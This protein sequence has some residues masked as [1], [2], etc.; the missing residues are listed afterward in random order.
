M[1]RAPPQPGHMATLTR[2]ANAL[3]LQPRR[4]WQF[5]LNPALSWADV[6]PETKLRL[7]TLPQ[8]TVRPS[9]RTPLPNYQSQ[10][11]LLLRACSPAYLKTPY[12][13]TS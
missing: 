1:A 12:T 2:T 11:I 10:H 9:H 13:S 3:V 5:F 4:G 7:R 8:E 6:S